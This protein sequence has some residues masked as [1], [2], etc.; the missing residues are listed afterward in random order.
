MEECFLR[1]IGQMATASFLEAE[2]DLV[3]EAV[4]MLVSTIW[5]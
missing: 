3:T 5:F 2:E 1:A 4:Q